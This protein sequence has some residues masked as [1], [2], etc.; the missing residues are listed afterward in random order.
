MVLYHSNGRVVI[1]HDNYLEQEARKESIKNR[2]EDQIDICNRRFED[3]APQDLV[4]IV[5]EEQ[6]FKTLYVKT[7]QQDASE[8][9]AWEWLPHTNPTEERISVNRAALMRGSSLA[10]E[11][12]RYNPASRELALPVSWPRAHLA[13]VEPMTPE[14]I[15]AS[16]PGRVDVRGKMHIKMLDAQMAYIR[17]DEI[18]SHIVP[19]LKRVEKLGKHQNKGKGRVSLNAGNCRD[20]EDE[21][22]D[23][24]NPDGLHIPIPDAILDKIH[25][26]NAMLQLGLPKFVQRPLI[27]ALILQMYKTPLNRC[28]LAT[29]E[30]TVGRFNSRSIA[31]LDPVLCHF[32]GTYP[33]RRLAD[34]QNPDTVPRAA[35]RQ[36]RPDDSMSE[37]SADEDDAPS[38]PRHVKKDGQMNF[39][40]A[41]R[42]TLKFIDYPAN[43]SEFPEDTVILPPE[44]PVLGHSIKHWSGLRSNGS[45]V[46]AFT[47]FPLNI[48]ESYKLIRRNSTDRLSANNVRREQTNR[49][50]HHEYYRTHRPGYGLGGQSSTRA[51]AGSHPG[52]GGDDGDSEEDGPPQDKNTNPVARADEAMN[53]TGPANNVK[54]SANLQKPSQAKNSAK[55]ATQQPRPTNPSSK[56]PRPEETNTGGEDKSTK[57]NTQDKIGP[58]KKRQR[59]NTKTASN[60]GR[61]KAAPPTNKGVQKK[62]A[63]SKK[64]QRSA[65]PTGRQTRSQT[66]ELEESGRDSE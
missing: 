29:L 31:I 53:S 64:P 43:R 61:K 59:T 28:H 55:S 36:D 13:G 32:V 9:S 57:A 54:K 14:Q 49:L 51:N 21:L 44:L 47:G 27:D 10:E 66:R 20:K 5:I 62:R 46:A 39:A 45:A 6:Y 40:K 26:Y 19:W 18:K 3:E 48:G 37:E 41:G 17:S 58:I 23:P 60:K 8:Y 30:M 25:L 24:L 4:E 65:A 34:R 42:Q 1:A 38:R 63:G 11:H 12:F 15:D 16:Y 52:D 2:Y 56:H 35:P 7:Y 50:A 22:M 33:F